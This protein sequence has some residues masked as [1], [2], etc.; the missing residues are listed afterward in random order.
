M[1][2][3]KFVNMG[4][5]NAAK[6]PDEPLGCFQVFAERKYMADVRG[7]LNFRGAFDSLAAAKAH[8][9]L[10]AANTDYYTGYEW[11][12]VADVFHGQVWDFDDGVWSVN[13]WD[14]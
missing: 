2:N 11:V 7:Y 14:L 13:G 9:E 10:L 6:S 12:Q 1:S 4:A 8:A 5:S 3:S